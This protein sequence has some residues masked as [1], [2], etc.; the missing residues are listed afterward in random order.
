M[1]PRTQKILNDLKEWCDR[2][3]GRRRE[4]AKVADVTT[5]AV[6]DWFAGRRQ[7]TAEQILAVLD[8]FAQRE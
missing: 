6:T 2:E 7:P 5:Q 3:R 4:I 8:F 1:P